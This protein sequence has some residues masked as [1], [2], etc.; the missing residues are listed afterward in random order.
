[1]YEIPH[2]WGQLTDF[3]NSSVHMVSCE[4]LASVFSFYF[5]FFLLQDCTLTETVVCCLF[6]LVKGLAKAT[7]YALFIFHPR[8]PCMG[9]TGTSVYMITQEIGSGKW[10]GLNITSL[11]SGLFLTWIRFWSR[12]VYSRNSCTH[13]AK[14]TAWR[15]NK[16][17]WESKSREGEGGLACGSAGARTKV[18]GSSALSSC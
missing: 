18:F 2:L 6:L 11:F 5:F 16:Q 12:S 9:C 14:C 8:C 13:T 4:V 1:M 3:E 7:S 15:R 17:E 10:S